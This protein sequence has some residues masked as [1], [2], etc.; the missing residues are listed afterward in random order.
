MPIG[1]ERA[2]P[3]IPLGLCATA[4]VVLGLTL[5]A[6]LETLLRQIVEIVER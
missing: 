5:P 1:E 4:L 6:P 3:L 2:W